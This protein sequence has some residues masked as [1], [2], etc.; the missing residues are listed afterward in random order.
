MK[1][2]DAFS[3]RERKMSRS[4]VQAELFDGCAQANGCCTAR[5]WATG[6]DGQLAQTPGDGRKTVVGREREHRRER[7]ECALG[8]ACAQVRCCL[9]DVDLRLGAISPYR[10]CGQECEGAVRRAEGISGA[11]DTE[12]DRCGIVLLACGLASEDASDVVF[13]GR[14]F[15][16]LV[17]ASQCYQN[18]TFSSEL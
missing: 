18:L 2:G 3:W 5:M 10:L 17:G 16:G 14:G 11:P 4:G 13:A 9:A 15:A 6:V 1:S 8:F 12:V 7:F